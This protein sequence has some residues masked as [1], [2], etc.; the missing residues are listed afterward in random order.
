MFIGIEKDDYVSQG[1]WH[2]NH[3][4]D[5][6]SAKREKAF[7]S[8]VVMACGCGKSVCW[9]LVKGPVSSSTDLIVLTQI[10]NTVGNDLCC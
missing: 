3:F 10:G 8:A 2:M 4:T 9:R 1:T 6:S 5:S 7:P